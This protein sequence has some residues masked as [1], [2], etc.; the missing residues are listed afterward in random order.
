MHGTKQKSSGNQPYPPSWHAMQAAL[1]EM[2]LMEKLGVI[3]D[4]TGNS[5]HW[6]CYEAIDRITG[7]SLPK[8]KRSGLVRHSKFTGFLQLDVVFKHEES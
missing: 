6:Y 2:C 4:M 5:N 8:D 7:D 1:L 3:P